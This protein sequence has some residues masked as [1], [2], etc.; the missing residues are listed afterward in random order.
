MRALAAEDFDYDGDVDLAAVHG[1]NLATVLLNS[2]DGILVA[3]GSHLV[4]GTPVAITAAD[5]NTDSETD[6]VTANRGTND[7]SVLLASGNGQFGAQTRFR[8]GRTPT[9]LAAD[10]LDGDG[11]LDL[12]TANRGSKSVNV[13]L[14]GADAPRPVVCLVPM[15]ARRTLV[16]ARQLVTGA[17][18]KLGATRRKYSNRVRRGRVI[19]VTP[20]AGTRLPVDS[21]VTLL[22][23][24]GRRR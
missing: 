23:S 2:G 8:T 12:V 10:D 24:R 7:I 19:A 16:K 14:Y 21:T 9:G 11:N 18:C 6:L 13:L 4:G 22:I 1:P 20:P 17:K 15:V 3:G 5:V